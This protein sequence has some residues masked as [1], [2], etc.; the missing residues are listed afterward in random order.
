MTA[1]DTL[2]ASILDL[3]QAQVTD[4]TGTATTGNWNSLRHVRIIAAIEDTYGIRL[5]PREARAARS[6]RALRL[7]LKDKGVEA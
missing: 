3:D 7:L 6:V 2:V 5:T 4:D 1:L